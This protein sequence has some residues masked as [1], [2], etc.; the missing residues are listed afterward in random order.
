MESATELFHFEV[1]EFLVLH[2][3]PVAAHA[4]FSESVSVKR[5][6]DTLSG[7]TPHFGSYTCQYY[8]RLTLFGSFHSV[9]VV[10]DLQVKYSKYY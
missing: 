9:Y 8:V 10:Q 5:R 1:P 7:T 3:H 4:D 2:D 6:V